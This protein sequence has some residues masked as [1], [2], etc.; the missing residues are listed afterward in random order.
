VW[1]GG[2]LATGGVRWIGERLAADLGMVVPLGEDVTIAFP[3]VNVVWKFSR[4]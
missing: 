3:M 1:S 2:G 4:D